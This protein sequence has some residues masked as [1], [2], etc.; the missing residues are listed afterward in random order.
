MTKDMGDGSQI[1]E[2]FY[3]R[4][5]DTI[6]F[7]RILSTGTELNIQSGQIFLSDYALTN[8]KLETVQPIGCGDNLLES[9]KNKIKSRDL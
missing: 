4:T 9:V 7:K 2:P 1:I 5:N 6:E 8:Q 3:R